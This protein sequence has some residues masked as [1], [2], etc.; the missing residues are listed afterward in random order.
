MK[1]IVF[2]LLLLSFV[3]AAQT[4]KDK[5]WDLLLTN[6]RE[7]ARKLFDKDLKNK[8]DADA[9]LLI[10]DALIE[11]ERGKLWYDVAFL[12]SFSK[13][14]DSKNMLFSLW[15]YPF[16]S[17]NVNSEG[18][19]DL[20]YE[21]MDYIASVEGW[22]NDMQVVYSKAIF[23]RRRRNYDG[24]ATNMAKLGAIEKWQFCG[25]F[26]NLNGSG[27][28][29]DY[30]PELYAKNDRMF[31]ANSN[32]MVNWYNPVIPQAEGFHYYSNESEYGSGIIYAQT[33]INSPDARTIVLNFTARSDLKIF[34][35][36][37][38]IYVNDKIKDAGINAYRIKF[39]LKKGMNRLVLK[40]SIDGGND[41][42]FAS[43][44]DVNQNIL[45][46]VDYFDTY[47]PYLKSTF[48]ELS[49]EELVPVFE[50]YLI[51]KCKAE[52][53]NFLYK[54]LLFNAYINNH[55]HEKAYEVIEPL[56]L[57]YPNSSLI[58]CMLITY[59]TDTDNKTRVDEINKNMHLKDEDYYYCII[60]KFRDSDFLKEA[61]IAQLEK[62]RDKAKQLNSPLYGLLYD[63]IIALRNA[64]IDLSFE[65]IDEILKISYNNDSF[66]LLFSGLH[67]TIKNDK[68]KTIK[69]LEEIVSR[70]DNQDATN[71]LIRYYNTVNRKEDAKK[72]IEERIVHYPYFN[73]LYND[74]ITIANNQNNYDQSLKYTD[75]GLKNFP[76]SFELMEKKGMAYNSLKNTAEAQKLFTQ[77]LKYNSGNNSL[78]KTL[79]TIS[80][81]P[82][83]T[84]QVATKDIYNVIKQRRGSAMPSDYGVNVLLD[85][86]I[87]NILPEGGRKTKIIYVYEVIAE[88]GVEELKEYNINGNNINIIKA[89]IVKPDGSLQ[90]GEQGYDNIVF[91]NLKV[92]DVIHIEYE[93]SNNGYGRF[94]KDFTINYELTGTY[95]SKQVTFGIIYPDDVTFDYKVN[96]GTVQ[97]EKKKINGRN[98]IKWELKNVPAITLIDDY[99]PNYYDIV[100]KISVSSIKS[101]SDIS[102][103]Y[104]DLVKK[105]L[106]MDNITLKVYNEIFPKG[107]QNLK[108][109]EIAYA[110]YKYIEENITY[111]SLDFRQSG[112]VPQKPSKTLT[113]KLGDCKDV[114]T[115][116][117]VLAERAG[118][119][120]NLVLIQTNDNG[121]NGL[122]LPAINFNHCIV[123][124]FIDGKEQYLEMTNKYLPYKV[125]PI[126][127]YNANALNISFDK[128]ENSKNSITHIP[129]TN[130]V[131]S[132]LETKSVVM[133]TDNLMKFDNIHTVTGINKPYFNE[134]FSDAVTADVRKKEFEDDYKSKLSKIIVFEDSKLISN[135]R[136][137]GEIK[138][139]T[140]FSIAEKLQSVGS[141]KI[142]EVPF[143]EKA[144]TQDIITA[145]KRN[146]DINYSAYENT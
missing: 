30:D 57:K 132:R 80:K 21:R 131:T 85:E 27:L 107:A 34:V 47:Q 43:L 13:F 20:A 12:K 32:G 76:Y 98:Y 96:N 142:M 146:Y 17:G 109:D 59:Y 77:S 128:A 91:T 81:T 67:T 9:E 26:E 50:E 115:L 138:Y 139:E 90:P 24:F 39:N 19:N 55:K 123:R 22:K 64:E 93:T 99:A 44:S 125:L 51:S 134:L 112:Y 133:V 141:L 48:E 42:F 52:P 31:N 144:Y 37:T 23:D 103:W 83:I 40:S 119:K 10:L 87:V 140:K 25:V 41:Y 3:A 92:G 35:D 105:T 6:K 78:R 86:Y 113:T 73:K 63:Y 28:E 62:Y 135:E 108:Q 68:D 53:S 84:D 14:P 121:I 61:N 117:V 56:A 65:K 111:S 2:A 124:V 129:F 137:A 114:S 58:N 130:A 16:V 102:N 95:P 145:E 118:L 74:A 69:I 72:L 75:V 122:N 106:K 94:Y 45:T 136:F 66:A 49:P 46:G 1:K 38:E 120:A 127:L 100:C 88:N 82:D 11:Q 71:A 101:W 70:H 116:F 33:F 18:Y 89:E 8:K 4:P 29:T 5:V 36:D 104:A 110:I 79:Y 7:E 97:P 126:S 143:T 15:N 60:D 54:L